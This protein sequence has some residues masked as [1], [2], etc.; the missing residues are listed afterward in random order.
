M[1]DTAQEA[2]E[3]PTY[4]PPPPRPAPYEE[5]AQE[6]PWYGPPWYHQPWYVIGAVFVLML[7]PVLAFDQGVE[8]LH[9]AS[10]REAALQAADSA[11]ESVLGRLRAKGP[12]SVRRDVV[13]VGDEIVD[14]GTLE[15]ELEGAHGWRV[16]VGTTAA[17]CPADGAEQTVLVNRSIYRGVSRTRGE[18]QILRCDPLRDRADEVVGVIAVAAPEA[19]FIGD[20][21]SFRLAL[22][23]GLAAMYSALVLLLSALIASRRDMS[24]LSALL[25]E[26]Q[27]NTDAAA[28]L[29]RRQLDSIKKDHKRAS[30]ERDDA[31]ATDASRSAF[32]LAL[33]GELHERLG[34]LIDRTE[35]VLSEVEGET[36]REIRQILDWARVLRV[37][38]DDLRDTVA[39]ETGKL[40]MTPEDFE[41]RGLVE[42][43]VLEASRALSLGGNTLTVVMPGEPPGSDLGTLSADRARVRQVLANLLSN[44]AKYTRD[45]SIT[46]TA[47]QLDEWI[48][49]EVTDDGVGMDPLQQARIFDAFV[50]FD[51]AENTGLGLGLTVAR[52]LVERMGGRLSV[53]SNLGEGSTFSVL[54]PS[55]R[56]PQEQTEE[57]PKP[58]PSAPEPDPGAA[59]GSPPDASS[60]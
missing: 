12:I 30:R 22:G 8:Q 6:P 40:S 27:S 16:H 3:R 34:R 33:T 47:R 55:K 25:A 29:L 56:A 13:Y 36:S 31:L 11:Q 23:S 5:S 46:L 45:G 38:I 28:D 20:L 59:S 50:R 2:P 49:F 4:G 44:A 42:E 9:L 24:A 41:P 19:L 39:I 35:R 26:T 60:S 48:R 58:E 7:L 21:W 32:L 1:D 53:K 37:S 54:L 14:P 43:L 17:A 18:P 10:V 15:A 52:G 57:Q 51:P